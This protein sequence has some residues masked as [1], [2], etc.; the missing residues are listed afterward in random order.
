MELHLQGNWGKEMQGMIFFFQLTGR[1]WIKGSV[2]KNAHFFCRELDSVPSTHNWQR[3]AIWNSSA[4]QPNTLSWSLW[5]L[6][7][8]VHINSGR[9]TSVHIKKAFKIK[10]TCINLTEWHVSLRYFHTHMWPTILKSEILYKLFC[11]YLS[12]LFF[13]S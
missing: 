2:G 7:H 6:A 12:P 8:V 4:R 1:D 10:L 9:H 5:V 13:P 3:K 11:S